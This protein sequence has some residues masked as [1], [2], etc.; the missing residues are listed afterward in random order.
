[1]NR[2]ASADSG[3]GGLPSYVTGQ[4][5]A[6]VRFRVTRLGRRDSLRLRVLVL[7]FVL[8]G[9]GACSSP[10]Y[11]PTT[12]SVNGRTVFVIYFPPCPKNAS[13]AAEVIINKQPYEYPSPPPRTIYRTGPLYAVGSDSEARTIS[14]LDTPHGPLLALRIATDWHVAIPF[15]AYPLG[16]ALEREICAVTIN[17]PA[18]YCVTHLGLPVTSS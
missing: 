2:S 9:A 15:S 4:V 8:L 12:R 11:E 18:S 3:T 7:T 10:R 6:A 17:A 1:M 5:E 14:G 13:C 16:A